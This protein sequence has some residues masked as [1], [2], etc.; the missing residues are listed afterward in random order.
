MST[1][2]T[3]VPPTSPKPNVFKRA[4]VQVARPFAWV[5]EFLIGM[6]QTND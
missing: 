3:I 6:G 1:G 4:A 2:P 5:A